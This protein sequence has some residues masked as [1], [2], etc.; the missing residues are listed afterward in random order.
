VPVRYSCT[1]PPFFLPGLLFHFAQSESNSST[2]VGI[3][4]LE[5]SRLRP[6]HRGAEASH[7][8]TAPALNTIETAKN[9]LLAKGRQ[10]VNVVTTLVKNVFAAIGNLLFNFI[11]Q[12]F[13]D[14]RRR[15]PCGMP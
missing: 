14:A 7:G 3:S 11:S 15:I 12:T 9:Q 6:M 1:I 4:S 5:A 8:E 13:T 10:A 2:S